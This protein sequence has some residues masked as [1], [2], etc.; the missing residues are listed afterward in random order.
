VG[1]LEASEGKNITTLERVKLYCY[2]YDPHQR[3]YAVLAT[4]VMQIGGGLTVLF[5]AGFI[6]V[7]VARERKRDKTNKAQE[8]LEGREQAQET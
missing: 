3:K 5:I 1:L 7:L 6:G 4:H 2:H 8:T